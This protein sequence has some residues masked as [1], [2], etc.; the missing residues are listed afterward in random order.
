M[1]KTGNE[2]VEY[3]QKSGTAWSHSY[4]NQKPWHPLS[5]PN[6]RRKWIAEQQNAQKARKAEE[7]AHEFSQQQEFFRQTA[8][9][10]RR[11]KEKVEALQAV[12]FMYMRPPGYNA[13]SARAAEIADERRLL[14]IDAPPSSSQ[15]AS[16]AVTSQGEAGGVELEVKKKPRVKD[17]FGRNVATEEEFAVLKDAPKM[18]TGVVG[19]VKPF[20]IEIRNVKCAK[21]GGFGHQSG[22]RECPLKDVITPNEMERL[23]RNDPLNAIIA[24]A[25][26]DEP[27]KWELKNQ[28]GA[29][30][31]ARGGFRPD[32]PNQQ[33]L[34]D[35][36]IYDEYGG[37]LAGGGI[38]DESDGEG[39]LPIPDIL[40]SLTKE[41][42]KELA[43]LRV[44]EKKWKREDRRKK[45][46]KKRKSRRDESSDESSDEDYDRKGKQHRHK[47]RSHKHR[48]R[49]QSD[50]HRSDRGHHRK[51]HHS[52]STSSCT[53]SELDHAATASESRD[54][55]SRKKLEGSDDSNVQRAAVHERH[56]RSHRSSRTK[57]RDRDR[58][59]KVARDT[60]LDEVYENFKRQRKKDH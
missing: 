22:D 24:Q 6:Q 13:E 23:K 12:S 14:G 16:L 45:R 34:A 52:D 31:P 37:F 42:R 60:V 11:E 5:Y 54:V 51:H 8:E 17:V 28:P 38:G 35:E 2:E 7:V 1:K 40:A 18:D 36:D 25:T 55:S 10:N 48:K 21:C 15:D 44:D 27:F 29:M 19:R 9:M 53:S 58:E 30:S 32:D 33:I 50:T 4:L 59:R 56:Y 47:N 41:Q 57:D 43:A 20:A 46:K 49:S 39:K 3:K 26:G